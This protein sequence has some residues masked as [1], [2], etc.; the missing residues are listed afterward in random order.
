MIV[1]LCN[2]CF[3]IFC[4]TELLRVIIKIAHEE[5]IRFLL[6]CAT[7]NNAKIWSCE[8]SAQSRRRLRKVSRKP[9]STDRKWGCRGRGTT[10]CEHDD[11]AARARAH[12]W[13][14]KVLLARIR[15]RWNPKANSR[16]LV[17]MIITDRSHP[18]RSLSFYFSKLVI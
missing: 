13:K 10:G 5:A 7:L 15:H 9:L 16:N 17:L 12:A 2:L 8:G 3:T 14:V 1:K 18:S 6:P 4:I 11:V